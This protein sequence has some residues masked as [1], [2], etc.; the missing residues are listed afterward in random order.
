MIQLNFIGK[1]NDV[2]RSPLKQQ[3]LGI[4]YN[5][6]IYLYSIIVYSY[7][8]HRGFKP[9][10]FKSW[11]GET[12]FESISFKDNS[13]IPWWHKRLQLLFRVFRYIN[14]NNK[15]SQIHNTYIARSPTIIY[16]IRMMINVETSFSVSI[17]SL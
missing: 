1:F 10:H 9:Y 4:Y 17:R 16:C 8:W 2:H 15:K 12:Q 5:I 6:S 7:V 11:G 13:Y 3:V 14:V